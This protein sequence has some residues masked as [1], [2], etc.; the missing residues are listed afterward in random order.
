MPLQTPDSRGYGAYFQDDLRLSDRLTLN[1]GLRWEYEPGPT[2]P[3]NRMSQRFDL[4]QP[5]PEMQATPPTMNATALALMAS[6]GYSY[7]YNGAWVFTTKD[8]P[9]VVHITPWNFLP[10]FGAAY[11]IDERATR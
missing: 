8:N 10:R 4:T 1:M 11:K 9:N 6:K 2:D 5:I 7:S 3:E